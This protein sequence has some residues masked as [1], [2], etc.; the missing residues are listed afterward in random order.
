M[1]PDMGLTQR[2]AARG[3]QAGRHTPS[4]QRPRG[5]PRR[6]AQPPAVF[7]PVR[8]NT[9]RTIEE[10]VVSTSFSAQQDLL[11][12]IVAPVKGDLEQMTFNLKNIVGNRHPMLMAAAEQIFGAGGKKLRPLVL[13][14]M[15]RATAQ[16][17]GLR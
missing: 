12:C 9:V 10:P 13:F 6:L 15:S 14:L 5:A 17:K 11:P 4:V 3:G 1:A 16:H 8:N 2:H 7:A